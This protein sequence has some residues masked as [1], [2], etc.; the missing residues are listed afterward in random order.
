MT[1]IFFSCSLNF[2]PAAFGTFDVSCSVVD[3][4]KHLS[5]VVGVVLE[6]EDGILVREGVHYVT[7]FNKREERTG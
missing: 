7:V 2:V 4:K 1:L 3:L 6:W 5:Y